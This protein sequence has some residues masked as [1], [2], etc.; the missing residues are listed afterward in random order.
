MFPTKFIYTDVLLLLLLDE[1][2]VSFNVRNRA[3]VI[4]TRDDMINTIVVKRLN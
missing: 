3:F 2:I 1:S 4:V